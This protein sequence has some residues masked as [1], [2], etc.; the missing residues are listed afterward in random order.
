MTTS[1]TRARS[2]LGRAAIS[3]GLTSTLIG[4]TLAVVAFTTTASATDFE[5][6]EGNAKT[7]ADAGL[8]GV[9]LEAHENPPG[10]DDVD[11]ADIQYTISE[12][13]RFLNLEVTDPNLVI[14]GTVVKAGENGY[15]VY[16]GDPVADMHAPNLD[17]GNIP[18]IS[19]W[20][21][22]GQPGVTGTETP[23]EPPTETPTE[24][25]T[26]TPTEPPTETPTEPPTESPTQTPTPGIELS[27][28]SPICDNDVPY[29][30]YEVD[31]Q[32]VDGT[33]VTITFVN[34]E[35]D[36]VV[37]IDQ[38]LSGRVLWAGAEVDADGNPVDWPGWRL[39]DGVWVEGDE[40]DWVRPS[41]EVIFEVNPTATVTV[42]YPPSS[43]LCNANPPGESPSPTPSSTTEGPD[44]PDTGVGGSSL[45]IA[46]AIALFGLGAGL[47]AFGR[48]ASRTAV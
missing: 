5:D 3:L 30:E 2:K 12:D 20:Y 11:S 43:P 1:D 14:T 6:F 42:D 26:E 39:E 31:A 15:R 18:Q 25:P 10:D 34:P 36:D 46:G 33:D 22:C 40:F 35:G 9:L 47:I 48:R 16:Y 38:P 28:L 8:E 37:Y 17:N 13:G 7:C 44:L 24:P 23:T 29:L 45:P 4:A 21:V 32:N 41:V 27:V 19:H